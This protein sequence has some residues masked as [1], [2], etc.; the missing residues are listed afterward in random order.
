MKKIINKHENLRNILIK[1]GS[2]E[3]GDLILDEICNLFEYPTTEIY[4]E[5]N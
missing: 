2:K 1:S 4:Y 3:Y 5:E